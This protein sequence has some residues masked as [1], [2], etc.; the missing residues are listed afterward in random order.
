VKELGIQNGAYGSQCV[1]GPLSFPFLNLNVPSTLLGGGS[2]DCLFL[3]LYVPRKALKD[4][5]MKLPVIVWLHG[6]AYGEHF[7]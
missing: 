3:D 1:Q 5:S 7:F 4:P 2:E 6:G